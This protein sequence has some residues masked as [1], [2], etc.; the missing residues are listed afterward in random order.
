MKKVAVFLLALMLLVGTMIGTFSV[1]AET[2]YTKDQLVAKVSE[3]A[4]YK[5]IK[6]DITNLAR[7]T[8]LTDAQINALYVVAEKFIAL[9][10][11]DK[12]PSAE[13]YAATEVTAVLGLV[14]EACDIM[15]YTY[16]FEVT[17]D[18]AHAGDGVFKVYDASGKMVYT[19]D[20][21]A[22]KK[23]GSDQTAL[24]IVI[25]LLGCAMLAAAVIATKKR[26]SVQA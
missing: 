2:Q 24:F 18:A 10:L 7:T 13:K 12:G 25:G 16:K 19:Y 22:V 20:G 21:D 8:E 11:T 3:S 26:T 15:N 14:Q 17:A 9:N 23:T 6:G 5:Y 1:S 4:I